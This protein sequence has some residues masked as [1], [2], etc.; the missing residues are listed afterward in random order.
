MD[1]H[2]KREMRKNKKMNADTKSLPSTN[3]NWYPGHMAK[4]RRLIK[5]NI[6]MVD[7]IYEVVDARIPF[8]SKIKDVDDLI[9]DKPKIMIMT[10]T[11]LCDINK[12]SMCAKMY[13]KEGFKVVMVDLIN[14]KGLSDI[15]SATSL[16]LK[17]LDDK[18]EAKGLK[19]RAYRA[20]IIGI[21]NVGKSTLINRL[22]GKKAT[23]TG[24]KP[25]VTK[26][27]SWIRINKDL[28]LLDSPGILWP[29][30]DDENQAY[31]LAS[32]SAI[33]EEILPLGKV[34]CYILDTM[35]KKYPDNLFNRYGNINYDNDDVI[36]AYETIGKK[37]GCIVSGGD[38]DYDKVSSIIIKDLREGKLGKV[39]FDE[40]N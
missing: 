9:K 4:T 12:T 18:R 28:E 5:E 11:D 33:K 16:L 20:L 21:P 35:D 15:Y 1:M 8:S 3:I 30:I 26:K 32:F 7:I 36:L 17:S 22:V 19:K 40:V 38:I 39:T 34:A 23:I 6:N 2:S 25:G 27:L 31:N 13:E 29:K 14:N 37:R 24:D 10:K